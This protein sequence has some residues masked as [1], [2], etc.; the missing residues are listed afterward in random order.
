MLKPTLSL[1]LLVCILFFITAMTPD[2]ADLFVTHG[3]KN[4][5][6]TAPLDA[7][8]LQHAEQ[9]P[10]YPAPSPLQQ[11]AYRATWYIDKN[12]LQ[13]SSLL[14][15]HDLQPLT[16][17]KQLPKPAT[18]YTG[19]L[20]VAT[21]QPVSY[22]M[23]G[24]PL[25]YSSYQLYHI[26]KGH[27]IQQINMNLPQYTAYKKKQLAL[28]KTMPSYAEMVQS[29]YELELQT[30]IDLYIFDND[31]SFWDFIIPFDPVPAKEGV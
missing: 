8:W 4:V 17:A 26:E 11:R 23:L 1:I 7:Y 22:D 15:W 29:L 6:L 19:I 21:G 25:A 5:M 20:V 16:L 30:D 28:Y 10:N 18:W 31:Q 2:E 14:G 3:K 9:S 12:Q 13:L 27:M 24:D